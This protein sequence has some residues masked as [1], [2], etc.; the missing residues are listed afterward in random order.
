MLLAM[1]VFTSAGE[2][3]ISW[4][5]ALERL[6]S[7]EPPYTVLYVG[8][9]QTQIM[10]KIAAGQVNFGGAQ[11]TAI[12]ATEQVINPMTNR[13]ISGADFTKFWAGIVQD[14]AAGTFFFVDKNGILMPIML[15]PH[16]LHRNRPEVIELYASYAS[17]GMSDKMSIADFGVLN[18]RKDVANTLAMEIR[19]KSH[20]NM[21]AMLKTYKIDDPFLIAVDKSGLAINPK[22]DPAIYIITKDPDGVAFTAQVID[23]WKKLTVETETGISPPPLVVIGPAGAIYPQLDA[24]GIK[25]RAATATEEQLTGLATP[26]IMIPGGTKNPAQAIIG[27]LPGEA[28]AAALEVRVQDRHQYSPDVP[29]S[30]VDMNV[31]EM[32]KQMARQ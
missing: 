7:K 8:H 18:G 12:T 13:K 2:G 1:V 21:K 5:R 22:T 16:S 28:V 9:P 4:D 15:L 30:E 6:R 24:M 3:V 29:I 23:L 20:A 10:R 19:A 25:Y 17:S 11:F 14:Y 26:M 32:P 31:G 27:F